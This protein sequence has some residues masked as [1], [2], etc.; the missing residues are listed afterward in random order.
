MSIYTS[1]FF[2]DATLLNA[3]H[4]DPRPRV[5]LYPSNHIHNLNSYFSDKSTQ[6]M[7]TQ[8]RGPARQKRPKVA[9]VSLCRALVALALPKRAVD[10]V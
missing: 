8:S 5:R 4:E 1:P 2:P 6:S 3:P 10:E 9:R 7:E